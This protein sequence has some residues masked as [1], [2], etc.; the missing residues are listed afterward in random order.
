MPAYLGQPGRLVPIRCQS[1]PVKRAD[2]YTAETTLEGAVKVQRSPG[3]R[4]S[5][6][7][8]L[9]LATAAQ[10]AALWGFDDGEWG[11]G[12]FVWVSPEAQ[13]SNLLTPAQASC[14]KSTLYTAGVLA[15]GPMS[16]GAD[17]DAGRSFLNPDPAV[18]F[19]FGGQ[20]A[21]VIPGRTV[22][23]SAYL[24]GA[25]AKIQI[26]WEDAAGTYISTSTSGAQGTAGAPVRAYLTS[27]P[28]ANAAIAYVNALSTS[29]A[30]RPALT[31]T[32]TLVPYGPGGGCP[33]AIVDAVERDP[34][35]LT[36]TRYRAS[37]QFT[38]T[39]VG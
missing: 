11:N 5:W 20:A 9:G 29:Q 1:A 39:E 32:D 4:R 24:I 25:G 6:E 13:V 16:L 14:D 27:T 19:R 26:R 28:P 23:A 18:T 10:I 7:V 8:G 12:P 30:A 38:V 21:P 2:R 34:R 31:W 33:K 35:V 36:D 3:A 37:A 15:G 17:G 22:T